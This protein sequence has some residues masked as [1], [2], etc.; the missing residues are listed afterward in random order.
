MASINNL[1]GKV[2][3]D[4]KVVYSEEIDQGVLFVV[5]MK[6]DP[7]SIFEQGGSSTLSIETAVI[8]EGARQNY[9]NGVIGLSDHWDDQQMDN[10]KY[11]DLKR[12]ELKMG[13]VAEQKVVP[14]SWK[15]EVRRVIWHVDV[16]KDQLLRIV[17]L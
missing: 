16:T 9:S 17:C 5:I 8:K 15:T 1:G 4:G 10:G 6:F 11:P 7:Y 3:K 14:L 2:V 12:V 13:A